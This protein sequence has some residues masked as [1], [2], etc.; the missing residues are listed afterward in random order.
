MHVALSHRTQL[1]PVNTASCSKSTVWVNILWNVLHVC[2]SNIMYTQ[3]F[4]SCVFIVYTLGKVDD[5][6]SLQTVYNVF[7][8]KLGTI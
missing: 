6:F 1:K 8:E 7:I 3:P 4:Q 5:I 2:I